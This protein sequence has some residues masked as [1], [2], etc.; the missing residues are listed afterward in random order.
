MQKK[1]KARIRGLGRTAKL[2][3]M[4]FARFAEEMGELPLDRRGLWRIAHGRMQRP[5]EY[6][7]S[8]Q[9]RDT[10]NR[11]RQ[12]GYLQVV[13]HHIAITPKTRLLLPVFEEE[14]LELERPAQWDSVWR[15]VIWDVP[16]AKRGARNRL[17]ATLTRLG[18]VH[19][20]HSV[21]VCPWPC[22]DEIEWLREAY[23]LDNRVLF[24]ETLQIDG[25]ERLRERFDLQ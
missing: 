18:F 24:F 15:V 4:E 14:T 7:K 16:E 9:Y 6:L 11:L 22:R 21:W 19:I 8:R 23:R 17:R 3:L 5:A 12:L 20:Q 10:V 25:D 1:V 2:I 13:H